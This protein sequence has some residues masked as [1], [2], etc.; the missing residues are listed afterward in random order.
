MKIKKQ[1]Q[2]PLK[3]TLLISAAILL[4]G[5]AGYGVYAKANNLWPFTTTDTS[6]N[7]DSSVREPNSVD[8]EGPTKEDTNNSQNAKENLLEEDTDETTPNEGTPET[9]TQKKNA[10]VNISFADIYNNNL[11]IRA[12]TQSVIEG[13]GTCTATV[14]KSGSPTI[15]KSSK[16]FIDSSSSICQPIYIPKSQLSNGTWNVNVSYS[17]PQYKGSSGQIKVEVK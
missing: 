1:S 17:S 6:D 14:S 9:P 15:T 16:A 7:S 3:K 10:A 12:F 5:A 13:S 11:E 4:V 2:S 8:Y